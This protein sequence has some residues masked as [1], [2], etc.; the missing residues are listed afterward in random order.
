ML[1]RDK[2]RKCTRRSSVTYRTG[3]DD[4]GNS[5]AVEPDSRRMCTTHGDW[6]TTDDKRS[7]SWTLVISKF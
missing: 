5:K 6:R 3:E 7:S 2:S 1:F 4:W